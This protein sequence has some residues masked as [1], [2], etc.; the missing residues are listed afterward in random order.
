MNQTNREENGYIDSL[1]G[2]RAIAAFMVYMVH[3][4]PF[5]KGTFFH[6]FFSQFYTGVSVFFV[7]SGFLITYRYF[8]KYRMEKKWFF[9]YIR[10]RVARIY[11]VY[12]LLTTITLLF[13]LTG[14]LHKPGAYST[15]QILVNNAWIYFTNITF[16]RGYFSDLVFSLIPQGWTLPIEEAF[17]FSAPFTWLLLRKRM[18]LVV[19]ALGLLLIG[20]L[21][22]LIGRRVHFYGFFATDVFMLKFTYFGKAAQFFVGMMLALWIL[23]KPAKTGLL[24]RI[25]MTYTGLAAMFLCLLGITFAWIGDHLYL[26]IVLDNIVLGFAIALFFG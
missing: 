11:P 22:V 8:G 26:T 21:F 3:Y 4:N 12:F 9:S 16:I 6:S 18:N 1:T 10:N 17:Y 24:S 25:N 19:Q 5:E 23:R 15:R 20:F 2:I 14:E 13:A 7:L